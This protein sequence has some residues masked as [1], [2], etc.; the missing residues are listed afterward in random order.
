[1]KTVEEKAREYSNSEGIYNEHGERLL[2][3]GYLA[4]HNKAMSGFYTDGIDHSN[5]EVNS[6]E[7]PEHEECVFC[8]STSVT[9]TDDKDICHHCGYVYE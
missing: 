3:M 1:M 5:L 6:H 4:G 2:H 7:Y 9:I 8:G